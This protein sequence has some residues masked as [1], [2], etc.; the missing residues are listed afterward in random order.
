M[1]SGAF[2]PCHLAAAA[3]ALDLLVEDGVFLAQRIV[4]IAQTLL[5]R[6]VGGAH[7]PM[8]DRRL[9]CRLC[10]IFR[11]RR[12]LRE[13][14]RANGQNHQHRRQDYFSHGG[15][16]VCSLFFAPEHY[17]A[18]TSI[19][20]QL[21]RPW[22]AQSC[23]VRT[24]AMVPSNEIPATNSTTK[25]AS[26]TASSPARLPPSPAAAVSSSRYGVI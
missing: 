6:N 21:R 5:V 17:R 4:W 8:A 20:P 9:N 16:P 12:T 7:L 23:T 19:A 14:I 24:S 10:R 3:D 2:A 26:M 15:S 18:G 11:Y 13:R 25:K 22:A 1:V